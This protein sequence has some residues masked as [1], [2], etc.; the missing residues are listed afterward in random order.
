METKKRY[1]RSE[2]GV[3][4]KKVQ[5][6]PRDLDYLQSLF[7][8]GASRST[9]VHLLV[10]PTRTKQ[11]TRMRLMELNRIPY[12]FVDKPQQQSMIEYA[13]AR[14]LIY[15]ISAKGQAI[16]YGH[17]RVSEQDI[18]MRRRLH[19]RGTYNNFWH[20]IMIADIYA[21]IRLGCRLPYIPYYQ[22]LDRAPQKTQEQ[23]KP[24]TVEALS[25]TPDGLFGIDFGNCYRFFLIE[26][27]QAN[28]PIRRAQSTGS[29]Y[30][31]KL[32]KYK[33]L[34]EQK[35]YVQHFG[36]KSDLYVLNV[37][38]SVRHMENIIKA[39]EKIPGDWK[40]YMLF[41]AVPEFGVFQR[42][43]KPTARLWE[44]EWK[45]A[46]YPPITLTQTGN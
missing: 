30:F 28:E 36:F 23:R 22:V 13:H 26:A 25:L 12:E 3:L 20:D 32:Q 38:T 46:G 4:S 14:D 41:Q 11:V 33:A 29:S 40:R 16:L 9:A 43:T 42:Q 27:D 18:E 39:L 31:D 34:I 15:D 17:G 6:V 5:I 19:G 45:R 8:N 35:I 37:T 1:S 7:D 10:A 44:N 2:R 24:M 21:S